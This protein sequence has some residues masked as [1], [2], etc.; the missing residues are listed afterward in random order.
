METLSGCTYLHYLIHIH[1]FATWFI[2][3]LQVFFWIISRIREEF[4]FLVGS[5]QLVYFSDETKIDMAFQL[6][7][8]PEFSKY[9]V[10]Y[11][12][13][14]FYFVQ[15]FDIQQRIQTHNEG[16]EKMGM[17]MESAMIEQ[18]VHIFAFVALFNLC[19]DFRRI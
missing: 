6:L 2:G 13:F 3:T 4:I 12:A 15:I 14:D 5:D 11:T 16:Q 1:A 19:F 10:I 8:F 17:C 9:K 18:N 7:F